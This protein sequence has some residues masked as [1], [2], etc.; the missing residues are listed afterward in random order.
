ME[1]HQA[2]PE[3]PL[4]L[5]GTQGVSDVL[6]RKTRKF[7]VLKINVNRAVRDEYT[8]FVAK[9]AG[10]L[11]LTKLKTASVDVYANSVSWFMEKIVL[12]A[13]KA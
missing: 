12:S 1:V 9:N 5:H 6:F 8:K 3:V 10:K 2:V 7:G 13:G 11:E 4:V